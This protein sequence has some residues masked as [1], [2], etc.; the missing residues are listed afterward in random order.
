MRG[1]VLFSKLRSPLCWNLM[2][3]FNRKGMVRA[4]QN[5]WWSSYCERLSTAKSQ[6]LDIHDVFSGW[7]DSHAERTL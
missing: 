3:F 4:L 7:G 2:I 6:L 5:Y 1:A